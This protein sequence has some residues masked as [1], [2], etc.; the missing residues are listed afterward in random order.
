MRAPALSCL[1]RVNFYNS[2]GV[3]YYDLVIFGTATMLIYEDF[4]NVINCINPCLGEYY[5]D[6]DGK[7]RPTVFLS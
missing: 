5:I 1:R 6:I 7:Y 3:F 2:I 4:D